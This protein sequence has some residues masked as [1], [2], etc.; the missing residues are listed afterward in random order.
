MISP[1]NDISEKLQAIGQ[2]HLLMWWPELT[3][4]QK[5]SLL[6][7]ISAVDFDVVQSVWQKARTAELAATEVLAA[8]TQP[9]ARADVAAAPKSVVRQ[10]ESD[11]DRAVWAAAEALEV[12][13]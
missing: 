7:Q 2:Q 12:S 11:E 10:P 1:P 8:A 6:Q 5:Q 13:F 3:D 9:I 4:T